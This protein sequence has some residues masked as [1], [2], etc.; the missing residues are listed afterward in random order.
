MEFV[1]LYRPHRANDSLPNQSS[2]E[3]IPGGYAL[4]VKLSDGELKAL[5]PTNDQATLS[6][7]GMQTKGAIQVKLMRQGKSAETMAVK[8]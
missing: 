6:S 1:T 4:Q 2:L 8:H 3:K 7:L 5:L